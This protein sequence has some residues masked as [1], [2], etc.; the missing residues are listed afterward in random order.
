MAD[1]PAELPKDVSDANVEVDD[2]PTVSESV[3]PVAP[4]M[5]HSDEDETTTQKPVD[6]YR[7][8]VNEL[9]RLAQKPV[10][11]NELIDATQLSK[12]QV[13]DWLKRAEADH[14]IK[15]LTRP[16][17]YQVNIKQ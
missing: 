12:T 6:F 4:T 9:N 2:A 16:V 11:V 5:Q 13:S 15:K 17:R 10:T 8:F 3:T 14:E 1:S 7:L